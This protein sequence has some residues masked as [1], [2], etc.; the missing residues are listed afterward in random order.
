MNNIF[1]VYERASNLVEFAG[2]GVNV[3]GNDAFEALH[4]VGIV[5]VIADGNGGEVG[6]K[7]CFFLALCF[8]AQVPVDGPQLCQKNE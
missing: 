3:D 1:Q 4:G 5:A 2:A 6:G 7:I 8:M